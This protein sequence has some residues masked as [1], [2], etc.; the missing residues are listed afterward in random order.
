MTYQL[1]TV[2]AALRAFINPLMP[3]TEDRRPAEPLSL[4]F[5]QN[6]AH[7][8]AG[9]SI[10]VGTMQSHRISGRY[11]KRPRALLQI[12]SVSTIATKEG[13]RAAGVRA[14]SVEMTHAQ[15][16]AHSREPLTGK[17][18]TRSSPSSFRASLHSYL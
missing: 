6:S 17:E 2:V 15:S 14:T 13:F 7:W 1:G 8:G 12:D 9:N 3:A 11:R 10:R 18:V 16:Y 4:D 5:G